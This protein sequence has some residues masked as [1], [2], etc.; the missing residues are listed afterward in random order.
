[1]TIQST[2]GVTI[3]VAEIMPKEM[4]RDYEKKI[5]RLLEQ[6]CHPFRFQDMAAMSV[7]D[8][9]DSFGNTTLEC[10][11]LHL[12][13]TTA[14]VEKLKTMKIQ[15]EGFCNECGE[16]L[17]AAYLETRA[18]DHDTPSEGIQYETCTNPKC[19]Y[20]NLSTYL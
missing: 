15:V 9:I 3:E 20:N 7:Y 16:M 13:Y 12:F 11:A 18:A 17:E 10:V 1:M 4:K 19:S 5:L 6:K 2:N 14:G 8:A